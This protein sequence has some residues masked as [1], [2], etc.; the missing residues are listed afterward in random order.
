MQNIL[1]SILVNGM[2]AALLL[3]TILY[4][5]R[6]NK[7]IRILQDSKSELARIITEFN[8]STERATQSIADIH[9]A[10]N[11]ISENIQHKIDRAN[12]I[13]TDLDMLIDKGGRMAGIPS[14][15][16]RAPEPA[17]RPAAPPVTGRSPRPESPLAAA[18][19][20]VSGI[21]PL[22][23]PE[24]PGARRAGANRPRSRAEQEIV[25]ALKTKN[26]G[27]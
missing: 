20:N 14:A 12:F 15:A 7:R 2:M 10:T 27:R 19:G 3:V 13:A 26:D 8:E 9:E 21:A 24:A 4:C 16:P 11:R 17:A 5:S 23:E 18:Q 25:N 6:L 1:L 22:A